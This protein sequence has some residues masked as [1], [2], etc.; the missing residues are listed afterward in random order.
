MSEMNGIITHYGRI[1]FQGGEYVREA[2]SSN[3]KVWPIEGF[4]PPIRAPVGQIRID[5]AEPLAQ[6]YTV[7]VTAGRNVN[8]PL[9]TA[10]YGNVDENGFV[11]HLW[12]TIAD[13]TLQNGDFSFLVVQSPE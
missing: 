2:G 7:L 13:R 11:V 6:P 10:N 9:M 3:W 8:T 1:V 4:D 5:F 12:E